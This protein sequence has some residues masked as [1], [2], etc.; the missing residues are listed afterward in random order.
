MFGHCSFNDFQPSPSLISIFS[1]RPVSLCWLKCVVDL[2]QPAFAAPVG[3]KMLL[4]WQNYLLWHQWFF[5][6]AQCGFVC[7]WE[8][9]LCREPLVALNMQGC[10][11]KAVF[12]VQG[13]WLQWI[14]PQ[15]TYIV[16]YCQCVSAGVCLN[17]S[18]F[19]ELDISLVCT[20][21]VN[22]THGIV[23]WK[24][25]YQGWQVFIVFA[26]SK[27]SV[28]QTQCSDVQTFRDEWCCSEG[29]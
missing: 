20:W 24:C 29:R 8:P 23:L 6:L 21:G 25:H 12:I 2:T 22:G 14:W 15:G 19:N 4:C 1:S 17:V 16:R 10:W 28:I 7:L 26:I 5:S 27:Y 9:G 18:K 13:P 3:S 11:R